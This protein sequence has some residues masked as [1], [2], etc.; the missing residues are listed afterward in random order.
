MDIA[1]A[2]DADLARQ[3]TAAAIIPEVEKAQSDQRPPGRQGRKKVQT[4]V[5]P[6]VH[7]QI[8]LIALEE[9][10]SVEE[11]MLEALDLLFRMRGRPMIAFEGRQRSRN[12]ER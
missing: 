1:A 9:D 7:K 11:L 6:H 10:T 3:S 12:G 4:H 8:H 2:M 5:S